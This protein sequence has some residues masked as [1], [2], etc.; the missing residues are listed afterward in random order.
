MK[1]RLLLST[2]LCAVVLCAAA[3]NT[4][5]FHTK[6][7]TSAQ[8]AVFTQKKQSQKLVQAKP[9][10]TSADLVRYDQHANM[11]KVSRVKNVTPTALYNRPVGTYIPSMIG[12][13]DPQY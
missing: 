1:K 13:E 4:Q 2:A 9:A 6:K 12:N 7:I 3:F 8:R 10:I 5:N 11:L